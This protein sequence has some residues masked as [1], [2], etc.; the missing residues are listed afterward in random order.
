M[1][2]SLLFAV[3]TLSWNLLYGYT[4]IFSFGH[5]AFFGIG[6]YSSALLAMKTGVSPWFALPIGGIVAAV[7]SLLIGLPC[8]K[9]RLGPYVA[10]ATYGFAEIA[11]IICSNLVGLTRGESGLWGIPTFTDLEIGSLTI[12]FAVSR[13]PYYY[14]ILIIFF[15]TAIFLYRQINSPTG[16][17]L[18]SIRESL[19]AAESLGVS[20]SK[21]KLLAFIISSFVAGVAGAFYAH[22]IL[23]LTPSCIFSID[24]MIQIVAINLIG[25]AG[26]FAAPIAGAFIFT[27][28]IEYLRTFG[29]YQFMLY[30]VLLVIFIL[31][32][33]QG[34]IHRIL[35]IVPIREK[36]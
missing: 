25:G 22:Y 12:N 5:Q 19:D 20:I 7:L 28:G 17:A 3:L 23:I 1:I 13:I 29:E 34:V 2:L 35:K 32:L 16:L 36:L 6:A 14:V 27:F 11:R 26:T 15:V 21:Y 18:K 31:F 8:L 10:I 24:V 33:P 30:G 9:L 4:G